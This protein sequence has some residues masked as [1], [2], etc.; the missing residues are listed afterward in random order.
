MQYRDRIVELCRVPARELQP[1]P[2][3]WRM[4]GAAQRE[5]LRGILA[6]IGYAG[7]LLARRLADGRLELIDGH[8]RA[9]TSPDQDV[10][11]LMLD[12]DDAEARMLLAAYDSLTSLAT[13]NVE[14]LRSLLGTVSVATPALGEMFATMRAAIPA[15][16]PREPKEVH[17]QEAF[18]VVI[19]CSGEEQQRELYARL[20]S[21][22]L[23]C[24]LVT[25]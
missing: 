16:K 5:A 6:E 19:D 20:T 10:P 14:R 13:P 21:E 25:M 7:A 24:R 18:Q 8:L 15:A 2:Q 9:E 17:V 11:V 3:N 1:H 23:H 4:H 22:G 12:L